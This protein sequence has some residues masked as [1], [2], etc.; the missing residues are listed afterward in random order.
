LPADAELFVDDYKVKTTGEKR[1]FQSS[2][3]PTGKEYKYTLKATWRGQT[4]SRTFSVSHE[5]ANQIDLRPDLEAALTLP[6]PPPASFTLAAPAPVALRPS[7]EKSVT[8][9]VKREN[10]PGAIELTFGAAPSGVVIH[11]SAVPAGKDSVAVTVAADKTA[12][13]GDSTVKVQAAGAS[14]TKEAELKLTVEKAPAPV[15][16]LETPSGVEVLAGGKKVIHV[17]VGRQNFDGPVTVRFEGLPAG[18]T[19][20]KV[21][22]AGDS[23]EATA[24]A[25]AGMD[26]D[27]AT[28]TVRVVGTA[29]QVESTAKMALVVKRPMLPEPKPETKAEPK[30]EPAAETKPEP[31]AEAK[32][33]PKPETKA[34]PKREPK[35]EAKPATKAE[36]TPEAN[37]EPRREPTPENK[38]EPRTEAKPEPKPE[39]KAEAGGLE[40][41]LPDE[42]VLQPGEVKYA[43]VRV[44][45][46]GLTSFEAD[47]GIKLVG[48]ADDQVTC[49]PWSVS[50]KSDPAC[51]VRGY[52]IKAGADAPEKGREVKVLVDAGGLN[53]VG[54]LKVTVKKPEPKPEAHPEVTLELTLPSEV[55][56]RPGEVKYAEIRLTAKGLPSLDAADQGIKLVGLEDDRVKCEAW[57]AS[58]K[59]DPPSVTRGYAIRAAADAPASEKEVNVQAGVGGTTAAGKFK[60]TVK[61]ADAR[62]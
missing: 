49:E 35:I 20:P 31:R 54:R 5:R 48:L 32:P 14:L 4:V 43:E 21:T 26:A 7:E 18:V 42:V 15:L 22:V 25:V 47:P 17:H 57:S 37:I 39:P 38:P 9:K 13:P 55:V 46:K 12:T 10:F 30:R 16:S 1:V 29:D 36:P 23:N 33:E 60:I 19:I 58:S 52:A 45:A 28:K 24:E 56:L 41:I 50:S 51:Y 27:E 11:N 2:P 53:A 62:P 3:V 6:P 61:P 40:L 44:R 8:F 34:E 59:G